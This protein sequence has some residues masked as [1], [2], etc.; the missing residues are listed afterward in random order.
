MEYSDANQRPALLPI[1]IAYLVILLTEV[2]TWLFYMNWTVLPKT[3]GVTRNDALNVLTWVSIFG[4][5]AGKLLAGALLTRFRIGL[6]LL[7]SSLIIAAAYIVQA[8]S[9]TW[10]LVLLFEFIG[11]VGSALLFTFI[12]FYLMTRGHPRW[13]IWSYAFIAMA[14]LPLFIADMGWQT[15]CFVAAA[16]A[17]VTAFLF[18]LSWQQWHIPAA[19]N[20]SQ[21]SMPQPFGISWLWLTLIIFGVL[22]ILSSIPSTFWTS[23]LITTNGISS[24]TRSTWDWIQRILSVV[25]PVFLG[26]LSDRIKLPRLIWICISVTVV[27]M[28]L[29]AV[30]PPGTINFLGASSATSLLFALNPI[31]TFSTNKNFPLE[32]LPA[33]IGVQGAVFTLGSSVFYVLLNNNTF[34]VELS[35]M[36]AFAAVI[37]VAI[38]VGLNQQVNKSINDPV[39][40]NVDS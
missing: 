31:L 5:I 30:H 38:V 1:G 17:I 22:G 19:Q 13:L 34:S 32:H 26:I 20:K 9:P 14:G 33:I 18:A 12:I 2:T 11:G 40:P 39:L 36:M 25:I 16:L 4:F 37:I 29:T 24:D 8:L 15:S 28:A 21:P 35:L 6:L 10:N 27:G 23:L 3:F 7:F